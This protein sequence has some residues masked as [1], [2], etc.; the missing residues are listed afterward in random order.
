MKNR[1]LSLLMLVVLLTAVAI[2][3]TAA[4]LSLKTPTISTDAQIY[5]EG[6]FITISWTPIANATGYDLFISEYPYGED[7]LIYQER[8]VETECN[9]MD[10]EPGRYRA[11][12]RAVAGSSKSSLSTVVYF[13]VR[14]QAAALA[15]SAS[16][17]VTFLWPVK[18]DPSYSGS[19]YC[20]TAMDIYYDGGDHGTLQNALDINH[21]GMTSRY[22]TREIVATAA[23]TVIDVYSCGHGGLYC[24]TRNCEGTYIKIQHYL[25]DPITGEMTTYISFYTHLDPK[26]VTVKEGD[27]VLQGQT[28]AKMGSSGNSSGVH[29]HFAIRSEENK[30]LPTLEFFMNDTYMPLLRFKYFDINS[31]GLMTASNGEVSRYSQWVTENYVYQDGLWVYAG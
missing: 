31:R 2:P 27:Y 29:L 11:N 22:D 5:N 18:D 30:D 7:H 28:I 25:P 13:S 26:T 4:G 6:D 16:E 10:L 24:S 1:F 21:D 12:V 15:L 20:I 23:G 3:G 19:S 9:L 14:S 17:G 8:C